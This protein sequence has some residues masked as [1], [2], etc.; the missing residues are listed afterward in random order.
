IGADDLPRVFSKGFTGSNGRLNEKSTGLGLYL[1]KKIC[2]KLE[3]KITIE[4]V[5]NEYTLVSLIFPKSNY[6][7]VLKSIN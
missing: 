7:Q 1:V 2:E 6:N 5:K 4:S 3:H